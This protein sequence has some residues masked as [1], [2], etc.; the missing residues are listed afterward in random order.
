MCTTTPHNG[1]PKPN[2]INPNIVG[3]A[4]SIAGLASKTGLRV[5]EFPISITNDGFHDQP[6]SPFPRK[7]QTNNIL[8][9][10][11]KQPN[12][13]ARVSKNRKQMQ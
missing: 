10:M 6:W 13:L 7:F 12:A 8:S 5:S 9:M 4:H 3:Y 2:I 11:K 1:Y